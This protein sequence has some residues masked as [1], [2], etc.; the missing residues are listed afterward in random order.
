MWLKF[1]LHRSLMNELIVNALT[2]THTPN[3]LQDDD[4]FHSWFPSPRPSF[5]AVSCQLRSCFARLFQNFPAALLPALPAYISI[6]D[7]EKKN[8]HRY[9]RLKLELHYINKPSNN[10][11]ASQNENINHQH[12]HLISRQRDS[13]TPFT[14][15]FLIQTKNGY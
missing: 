11:Y 4:G 2:D 13:D 10:L 12:I 5:L 9:I 6:E 7:Q 3:F 1:F 8:L 15:S 14:N